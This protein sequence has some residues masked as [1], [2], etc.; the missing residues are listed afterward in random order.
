MVLLAFGWVADFAGL[1]WGRT[2]CQRH[3]VCVRVEA[4]GIQR[5]PRGEKKKTIITAVSSGDALALWHPAP[6]LFVSLLPPSFVCSALLCFAFLTNP[7]RSAI[8][9]LAV[10]RDMPRPLFLRLRC[11]DLPTLRR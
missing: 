5:L 11:G 7:H 6:F 1:L 3:R 2:H 8:S 9:H 4:R 10:G